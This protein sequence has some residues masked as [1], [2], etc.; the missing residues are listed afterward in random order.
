MPIFARDPVMSAD[1]EIRE[2]YY[3]F[4]HLGCHEQMWDYEGKEVD[5][6]VVQK[7]LS[8]YEPFFR[9]HRLGDRLRVTPR[10]PNPRLERVQRRCALGSIGGSRR[11]RQRPTRTLCAGLGRRG[12]RADRSR[13]SA[14]GA[15]A[16]RHSS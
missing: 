7:L 6:S 13:S 3:A 8:A 9:D 10:V 1:D 16:S 12:C 2:A 4:S 11:S 14:S 15:A 5:N